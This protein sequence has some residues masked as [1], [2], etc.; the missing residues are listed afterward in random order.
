MTPQKT[1]PG[2]RR[3]KILAIAVDQ[4]IRIV[5]PVSSAFIAREYGLDLSPATIRHVL[6]ELEEE[7]YLTHPHTSAGRVPTQK[8][9][10]YYVDY[11]MDE[12][13]LLE[14]EK[15]RIRAEYER[16]SA[17]LDVLLEKTSRVLSQMTHYTTLVSVDGWNNKVF[18]QG[19]SFIV[20]Y[21]E[22]QDIDKTR[23]ILAAL[24][25]KERLLEVINQEL[26]KRIEIF[27]GDEI[28]CEDVDTCSLVV[29]RYRMKQGV[30]GR[31]AVLGPTRMD[32][33]KVVSIVDYF[34]GLME[35]IL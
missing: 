31:I 33:K 34:S 8:G 23:A 17:E 18:C 28:E 2:E 13:H 24:D 16:E 14:E 4:Y 27:I 9:Y 10:R 26:A 7:G 22:Y 32:Y 11:L 12:I 29:S 20:G 6:A 25:E 19:I 15:I 3:E 35:D 5:S 21:P 30:S 1:D